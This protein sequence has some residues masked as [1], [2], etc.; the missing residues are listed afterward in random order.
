MPWRTRGPTTKFDATPRTTDFLIIGGGII[1]LCLALGVKRR[2]PHC[3]VVILEKEAF[4]GAHASGRNSGV[5][6]AGF[7][8]HSDSLKAR[9]T[10]DGNRQLIAYCAERDLPV[11][12][13]GKLVVA[14]EP[15]DLRVF[16]ELQKRAVANGVIL[17][18]L[19]VE[20]ARRLEPR[21]R[22]YERVL[23]SPATA[24]V[25]PLAVMDALVA[26]A[27]GMGIALSVGTAYRGYE[28]G[29]VRTTRGTCS[30]GYVINSAGLYAD[31][32]ARD[33]GFGEWCR[34]V[35]FKGLYLQAAPRAQPLHTNVYPVPDLS[36]P[37]LGVH[38][39]V[40]A[41]RQVKVGPTAVPAL[42]REHYSGLDNFRLQEFWEAV[43]G[44]ASLLL[45]GDPGIRRLARRE[46]AK[47]SRRRL[48]S[49]AAELVTDIRPG[50]SWSWAPAGI[51]AQL[52]NLKARTLEMDFRFEGDNRSFHVLNAVSPA[53]TCALP[54][55]EY[56]A[57]QIEQQL[58]GS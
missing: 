52:V 15:A 58:G 22:S 2:Y 43:R 34:I 28:R 29:L 9:F 36:Q 14:R 4:C 54:F 10:R 56:L 31:V 48:L 47:Q 16:A 6:H 8:Y 18:E 46:L 42:W 20:E 21:V 25:D 45:W 35:P 5:L 17:E 40:T 26:D 3:S 37:F 23:F 30:A 24:T 7:Y 49:L 57:C 41:S 33:F 19:S 32:V 51:R 38:L 1:G 44:H 11:N 55:C 50:D 12:R 27:R 39:T 53:F 13:C